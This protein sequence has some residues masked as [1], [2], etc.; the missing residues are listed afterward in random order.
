MAAM[1]IVGKLIAKV[2]PRVLALFGLGNTALTLWLM[3]GFTAD[4]SQLTI[5]WTG[6]LQGFGLGFI[7]VP[8]STMTFATLAPEQRTEAAGLFSLMR[9]VGGSIGIAA[10]T[11]MLSHY[12]QVNHASLAQHVSPLNPM[13]REPYLPDAWSL[14]STAGLVQLNDEI[15]R[16]AMMI[17]YLDDFTLMMLTAFAA[18]PMLLLLRGKRPAATALAA[19]TD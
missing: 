3:T 5:V 7:F 1:F 13:F 2:D 12:E 18:A 8:V 14:D 11:A 17:A 4:V 6:I 10:V 15:G 16:Q 9:N 19:A